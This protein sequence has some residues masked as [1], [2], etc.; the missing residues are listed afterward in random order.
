MKTNAI[1]V[2]GSD[3][4]YEIEFDR[5]VAFVD[6]YKGD[7]YL[8]TFE[9]IDGKVVYRAKADLMEQLNGEQG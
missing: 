4:G 5:D 2:G 1:M 7:V 6:F 3:D 8:R 9:R